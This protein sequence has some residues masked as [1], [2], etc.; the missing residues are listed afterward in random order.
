MENTGHVRSVNV[1][2]RKGTRKKPVE[3]GQI[4]IDPHHGVTGDAHAGDWH[5][6]VSLLAWE[7]IEK[8][9]A[10][11]LDV[12]E[13]DFAENITT[14]GMDLLALPLGTQVKIGDEVVLELSQIGKVCHKKCAIYYLAG[15]CIFPRE[16]IFFEVVTGGTVSVG[17]AIVVTK[18][19]DGHCKYTPQEALDEI[20]KVRAEE[21]SEKAAK[22][23]EA[24]AANASRVHR[25]CHRAGFSPRF[26]YATFFARFLPSRRLGGILLKQSPRSAQSKS[27]YSQKWQHTT[28]SVD[29]QL[30]GLLISPS[31][32]TL[33]LLGYPAWRMARRAGFAHNGGHGQC[34][35]T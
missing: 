3:S 33:V 24:A 14:E 2:E 28:L 8:A 23:K 27:D 30:G 25:A 22:A 5:R 34:A 19:G 20:A 11:G 7:S 15:D 13:G 1:S 32:S 9:R 6:Q 10:M 12:K 18:M 35:Y 29:H 4:H 31:R 17:D 16:G 26:R 21:A